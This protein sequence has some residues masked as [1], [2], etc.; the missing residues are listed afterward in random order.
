MKIELD[1]PEIE[2]FEP[3]EGKQPRYPKEGEWFLTDM[4]SGR[5]EMAEHDFCS[6]TCII[7]KRKEP[8]YKTTTVDAGR[9]LFKCVE[10]KAVEDALEFIERLSLMNVNDVAKVKALKELIK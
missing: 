4:D 9:E 8:V 6:M 1:L 7:L 2:G 5:A 3:D 10:I